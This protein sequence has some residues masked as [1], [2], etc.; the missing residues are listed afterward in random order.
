MIKKELIRRWEGA[1][2]ESRL[3]EVIIELS[4]GGR[5][6]SLSWLDKYQDRWDLRGAKLSVLASEKKIASGVYGFVKKTGSLKLR[7]CVLEDVDFSFADISYSSFEKITFKNCV[8]EETIGKEIRV[9]ASVFEDTLFKKS[10]FSY[11]SMNENVGVDSGA[12]INVR[13]E[14][15]NLKESFFCFPIIQNCNFDDC[16]LMA[17]DFDG[18]RLNNCRFKGKIDSAWFGGYSL[19]ANKSNFGIFN[20]VDPKRYPNPMINVDFSEAVLIGVSF[21]NKIDISKCIFPK[22]PNFLLIQDVHYVFAKAK[23]EII[24]KWD[25]EDKRI[26]I[27]MIDN[28]YYTQAY[29]LQK[30]TVIDK[31]ILVEQFG[32]DFAGRFWALISSFN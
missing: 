1:S 12:F 22:D 25:G 17:V 32:E 10:N 6:S 19:R 15:T 29:H 9:V 26:G 2:G 13:F 21:R 20:Q 24:E 16:N 30:M 11:S 8:F 14:Q 31:Y 28:V 23:E 27:H 18:S 3:K 7:E 4:K 5:L